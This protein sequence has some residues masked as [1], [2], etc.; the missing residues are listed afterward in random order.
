MSGFVL[1]PGITPLLTDL[2]VVEF[3]ILLAFGYLW[4]AGRGIELA[5]AANALAMSLIKLVTDYSD[6]Y[7]DLVAGAT[8]LSGGLLLVHAASSSR[9]RVPAARAL[10]VLIA[11]GAIGL[12][13]TKIRTDFYDPFDAL[14]ADLGVVSGAIVLATLF[15]RPS[16]GNPRTEEEDEERAAERSEGR[17][18]DPAGRA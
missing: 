16:P 11:V 10:E 15:R 17:P 8:L 14:L 9:P 12:G 6:L 4:K 13:L 1:S 18:Q 3:P 2:F 7:D 5:I